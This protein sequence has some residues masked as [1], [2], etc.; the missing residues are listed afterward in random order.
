MF[1]SLLPSK[2]SKDMEEAMICLTKYLHFMRLSSYKTEFFRFLF[3]EY[4]D[5]VYSAI[6]G[7]KLFYCSVENECKNFYCQDGL[8]KFETVPEFFGDHLEGDTRVMFHVKHVDKTKPGNI[9][10]RA[11]DTDISVILTT[12]AHI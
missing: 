2:T 3:K 5:P 6:V 10:V 11:K 7:H 9:A 1:T 12:N 4:E 8:C